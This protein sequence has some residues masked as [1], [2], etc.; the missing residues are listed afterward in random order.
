MAWWQKTSNNLS[1]FGYQFHSGQEVLVGDRPDAEGCRPDFH[2]DGWMSVTDRWM[3]HPGRSHWAPWPESKYQCPKE[4]LFSTHRVLHHWINELGLKRIYIHCD[5][6]TH[7]APLIF[8]TFLLVYYADRID[9]ICANPM[10]YRRQLLGGENP[11]DPRYYGG[12]Y[13]K[14]YPE[15]LE[16]LEKVKTYPT[17]GLDEIVENA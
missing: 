9:E 2:I 3:P 7:R 4:V 8:G 5:G 12:V 1:F 13:F 6:G 11:S 15:D 16:F 17:L 14:E 10:R